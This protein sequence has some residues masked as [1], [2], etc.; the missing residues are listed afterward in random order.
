MI[1][2]SNL[3][4]YVDAPLQTHLHTIDSK[5][6]PSYFNTPDDPRVQQDAEE[7]LHDVSGTSQPFASPTAEMFPRSKEATVGMPLTQ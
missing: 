5:G 2:F 1:R 4:I 7:W 6:L 3:G